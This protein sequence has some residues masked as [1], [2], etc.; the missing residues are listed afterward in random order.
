MELSRNHIITCYQ[1][2]KNYL[3]AGGKELEPETKAR[4]ISLI[5][6]RFVKTKGEPQ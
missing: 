4:L 6:E 2:V 1:E 5:Y 3:K